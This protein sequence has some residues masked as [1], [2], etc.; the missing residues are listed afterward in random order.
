MSVTIDQA[1]ALLHRSRRTVYLRIHKGD[2]ETIRV[3]GSTR[4]T[5]DSL[6]RQPEFVPHASIEPLLT[7]AIHHPHRIPL[8][9]QHQPV[10]L[11]FRAGAADCTALSPAHERCERCSKSA[12]DYARDGCPIEPACRS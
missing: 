11:R 6:A 2:L 1:A 3:G 9:P 12:L 5:K 4:V 8:T 7:P 10:D